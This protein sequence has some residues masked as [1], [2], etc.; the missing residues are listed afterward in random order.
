MSSTT[1]SFPACWPRPLVCIHT[2][3]FIVLTP[4]SAVAD[5]PEL[6]EVGHATEEARALWQY[7]PCGPFADAAALR[8]WITKWQQ[9]PDVLAFTVSSRETGR[10]LGMISIMRI[11][12]HHG[13]AELGLIWY[14]PA[15]QRT[16]ANTEAVHL[17]LGHLFDGLHYRRV[18]WKCDNRNQPSKAAALRLGF[19]PEGLF[20]QHLVVKG[21]N[22]DTAWFAMLDHEWP[23][24]KANFERWLYGAEFVSLTELNRP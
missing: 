10:K 21:M 13:V 3:S 5:A 20:R 23:K 11:T 4:T 12:P 18:E 1:A 8:D 14:A 15:A 22:R 9:S 7:L 17:L 24:R 6:F 19:Q 16:K 2:G